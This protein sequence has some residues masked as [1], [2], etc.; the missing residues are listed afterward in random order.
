MV[1]KVLAREDARANRMSRLAGVAAVP[2]ALFVLA[3]ASAGAAQQTAGRQK[4][5][6]N[7]APYLPPGGGH[8]LVLSRCTGC[9]E[10]RGTLQLRKSAPAWEAIVL[11]MGARGAPISIEEI[12]PLVKYLSA[13]FGPN[14]PPF[15]DANVATRDE[16]A[17][18]PGVT[19][20]AAD[21]LIAARGR[22]PLTSH[23]EVRTAL[24][25]D[26]QSFE[27][28]RYYLYVKPSAAAKRP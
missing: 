19:P 1:S 22:G 5:V 4:A 8:A 26:T 20:A 28:I 17:K 15:T 7:W 27:K 11:D 14:A 25:L 13:A 12:D 2:W 18:L 9:H 16:L 6:E 24:A 3:V 23:E 10:L 21:R